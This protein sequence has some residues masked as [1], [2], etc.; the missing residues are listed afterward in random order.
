VDALTKAGGITTG[1]KVLSADEMKQTVEEVL[2]KGDA[3]RGEAV[4][5]AR[6]WRV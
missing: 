2:K 1:P 5:S 6:I 3:A 4:Y